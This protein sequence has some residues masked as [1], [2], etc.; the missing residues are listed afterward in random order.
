MKFFVLGRGVPRAHGE[1]DA[2]RPEHRRDSVASKAR[3]PDFPQTEI[4][5][6]PI[7]PIPVEKKPRKKYGDKPTPK[8]DRL[9]ALAQ[10][11]RREIP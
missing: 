6:K 9:I 11:L 10:K 5:R 4:K 3:L 2:E 7:L 8:R 1:N